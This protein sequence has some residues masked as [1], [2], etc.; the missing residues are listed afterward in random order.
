MSKK[1]QNQGTTNALKKI[2]AK[3]ETLW[4]NI[5]KFNQEFAMFSA[6]VLTVSQQ[7]KAES[8]EKSW[9]K[10]TTLAEK[11][12]NDLDSLIIESQQI[13]KIDIKLPWEDQAFT[14]LWK[15]WTEYLLEQHNI[16][17]GTRT[18]IIQLKQLEKL[19]GKDKDKAIEIIEW[20]M[21]NFYKTFYP[22]NEINK[23]TNNKKRLNRKEDDFS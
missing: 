16:V 14:D 10:L 19:S 5:D 21:T 2:R 22:V 3:W 1:I 15:L 8:L 7:I 4:A 13:D 9:N 6:N 17:V 20:S 18:Q 11:Y 23:K 12:Y